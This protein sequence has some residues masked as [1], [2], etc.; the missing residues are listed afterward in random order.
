MKTA[1]I[2]KSTVNTQKP[3]PLLNCAESL[4]MRNINKPADARFSNELNDELLFTI[5]MFTASTPAKVQPIHIGCLAMSAN[6][7]AL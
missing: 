2:G 1:T 3:V 4:T 5:R 7:T 6:T